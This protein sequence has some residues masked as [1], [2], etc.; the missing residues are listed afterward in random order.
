MDDAVLYMLHRAHSFLDE[1]GGYVRVLFLDFSS[2]FDTIQPCI[3]KEKMEVM[4][5]DSIFVSWIHSYLTGRLQFVRLGNS[6]SSRLVSNVGAPQGTVL[7]PF[8]FT[9]YTA[10]FKYQS[11]TCHIHK[12]SDD[13]AIVACIKKAQKDEY[14][15]QSLL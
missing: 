8:L 10:D 14:R 6:V 2:A 15:D 1:L 11:E 5:V 13:T 12:Y 9:P 7:A 3:L 4:G